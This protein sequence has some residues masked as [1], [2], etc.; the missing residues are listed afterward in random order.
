MF[1]QMTTRPT[2]SLLYAPS[3]GSSFI[4]QKW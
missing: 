2:A 1:S 3:H 4:S